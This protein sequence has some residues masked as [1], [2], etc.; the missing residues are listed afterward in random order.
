MAFFTIF[1]NFFWLTQISFKVQ[2][3]FFPHFPLGDPKTCKKSI[4]PHDILF[5]VSVMIDLFPI[6]PFFFFYSIHLKWK[7]KKKK[8]SEK[9]APLILYL[10]KHFSYQL[11]NLVTFN[12]LEKLLAVVGKYEIHMSEIIS[13][14]MHVGKWYSLFEIYLFQGLN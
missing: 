5:P 3:S 10:I 11:Y 9:G 13:G 6:F 2:T 4:S 7:K 1:Y 8:K 12:H 14:L